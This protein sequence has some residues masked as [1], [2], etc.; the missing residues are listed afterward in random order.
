MFTSNGRPT[1]YLTPIPWQ[2]LFTLMV[3]PLLLVACA[4]TPIRPT[5]PTPL[6]SDPLA[7]AEQ[8]MQRGEYRQ[9]HQLYVQLAREHRPPQSWLYLQQAADALYQ[10]GQYQPSIQLL[11]EIPSAELGAAARFEHQ[12][13]LARAHLQRDADHALSLL[14]QPAVSEARLPERPDLFARYHQLRAESFARLRNPLESAREYVLRE[15]F[16]SDAQA[17]TQNQQAIWQALN[18]MTPRLLR[19]SRYQPPPDALSGWM[20]LAELARSYQLSQLELEE[21]FRQWRQRYPGH[22]ATSEFLGDLHH[23]STE[24]RTRP[25]QI[26]VMLP[27]SGRLANAGRAIQDGLL[28]AWFADPQREQ[29]QLQFFDVG[30]NPDSIMPYYQQAVSSGADFVLGPLD[31]S[32]VEKLT[33]LSQL[34]LPTLAFNQAG[35]AASAQLYQFGLLP[36][37]EAIEA[38]N[39]AWQQGYRQAAM[40]IPRTPLGERLGEAFAQRWQE[41]GGTLL[42]E[43]PYDPSHNDFAAPIK[44]L[45]NITDSELRHRR[46]NRLSTRRV[47]FSPRVRQ[48]IDFIFLAAQPRQARLIRPQLRFHHAGDVP[49][50]ATSHV[51]SGQLDPDADRDMDGILFCDTPWTLGSDSLNSE[52]RL[53]VQDSVALHGGQLQRLVAMGVD[54][55]HILPL[56]E[57]LRTHPHEYYPGE[58]GLLGV[59]RRGRIQRQLPWA[60]FHRGV[61][62]LL[63]DRPRDQAHVSTLTP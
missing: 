26:A 54:A 34:P 14:L 2:K 63:H 6:P 8:A 35:W 11:E 36:E 4:D 19:E 10:D 42:S 29:T 31:R 16:L 25:Q 28:S 47:E 18:T 13:L 15:F 38:A 52:L 48:D 39:Y 50:L 60:R 23:R 21:R 58:T 32:A 56:L 44:N 53:Q 22:P 1:A 33:Q 24:L 7:Q 20:E 59:D 57:M 9:A 43:N 62:Q 45:L 5:A 46:I 12:L 30:D 41:L 61:P 27:L 37:D 49:V 17:I 55:Y 3:L 51:F 40:M